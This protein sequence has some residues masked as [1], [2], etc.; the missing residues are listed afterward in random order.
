MARRLRHS[1]CASPGIV[2]RRRGRGF[3]YHWEHDGSRVDDP[4][5]LGR[6]R[7]LVIPPAWTDVWICPYENGHIQAVGRDSAGRRQYLYHELW[8]ERRDAAKHS[9]I[10]EI[11]RR[12]PDVRAAVRADLATRGLNRRRV[13]A[14]AVRLLDL[15][16]FRIGGEEYMEQNGSFGLATVRR[17]HVQVERGGVVVFEYPAKG[18]REK[19]Q[20]VADPAVVKLV[21]ALLRRPDPSPELLGYRAGRRWHNVRSDEINDHLKDL[22]G[23]PVT[24]KDFRT[25]H[26]TV[27]AAV[28]LA[29][30]TNAESSAQRKRAVSRVMREVA[31]Y[32]GNTPAV[33]RSSYVDP[34][35][36]DRFLDGATVAAALPDLGKRTPEGHL[37]TEGAVER[38]VLRQLQAS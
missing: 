4:V 37:A 6:V 18:G 33:A 29:V 23:I 15:G 13:L 17:E 1:D 38:A 3:S 24:A 8:R 28:G 10:A 9:H 36:V 14:A 25:W 2:R 21:R 7:D 27:L 20:A 32:L 16:F 35:I 12:L 22:F 5:A 19:Y 31:E 11:A 30:S 26:A 34:R